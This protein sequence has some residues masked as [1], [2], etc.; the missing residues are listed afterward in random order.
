M[1]KVFVY[2]TLRKGEVNHHLLRQAA[3][4]AE[5]AWALGT[6]YDT[7]Y[8]YPA[9]K[10]E[11]NSNV[12]GELYE[13]AEKELARLDILEDYT[14]GGKDNLYERIQQTVYTDHGP[15]QAYLYVTNKE[16]LLKKKI[17]NGDWKEYR[18]LADPSGSVLYF[19]YGSCMDTVR[20]ESDGFAHYFQ[21]MVGVG[22]LPNYTLRF[23]RKSTQ[24][25]W[26]RAD[27]VEEGGRVEG[28]VYN[29]PVK[30]LTEYLY[31]REGAP[32][33]YRPTFVEL[34]LNGENILALTFV[35]TKK[36]KETT[37][38]PHYEQEILRGAKDFLSAPYITKLQ[39]YINTLRSK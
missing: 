9:M 30:A 1:I 34:E 25:G 14:E 5:Q 28:K 32:K 15:L 19:A 11:A 33:A 26:G 24:D 38:P 6:L 13:V 16:D 20:F 2:G 21:E 23:T 7:G 31:H 4:M 10:G 37:P 35:V 29:I 27:I 36:D 39:N 22:V 18:L 8:G 17:P 12:Y 3:C